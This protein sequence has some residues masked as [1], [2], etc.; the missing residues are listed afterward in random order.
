MIAVVF[1]WMVSFF[2]A[3]LFACKGHFDAWWQ[4]YHTLLTKCVDANNLLVGMSAS[5]MTTDA[6]VL[7]LPLPM[8]GIA[9]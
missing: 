6:I 1:G 5:D 2:F 8:V 9:V 4:S 3:Y 7:L